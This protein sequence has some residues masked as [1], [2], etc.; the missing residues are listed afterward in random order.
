[1]KYRVFD[2]K[3]IKTW[4][5]AAF[6]ITSVLPI[7]LVNMISYC[8]TAS[9]VRQNV[10]SLTQ[11]NLYQTK[12]SLDVW[13]ESYEDILYQVY[14]DDAIVELVDKINTGEDTANNRKMLRRT[15]RGLVYTKDHINLLP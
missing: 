11:A 10:D 9:L 3:S 14:T 6:L 13:M 12:S 4:M 5:I 8:N 15:L 7:L 1:M 2:L